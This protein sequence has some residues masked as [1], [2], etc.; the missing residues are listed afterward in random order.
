[1]YI[2]VALGRQLPIFP[3]YANPA[4]LRGN[5]NISAFIL[6]WPA[7]SGKFSVFND[8]KTKA[9]YTESLCKQRKPYICTSHATRKSRFYFIKW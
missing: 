1:M 7:A 4:I 8:A 2:F 5:T 6:F 3:L 9:R